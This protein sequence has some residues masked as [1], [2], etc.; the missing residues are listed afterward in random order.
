MVTVL[1]KTNSLVSQFLVELRDKNIQLDA[2][3]FRLNMHRLGN[4]FAY[5][6][7]K[8]L[9]FEEVQV[10]T[11]LGISTEYKIKDELCLAVLL[12][13]GLPLHHGL[14]DFFPNAANGFISANRHLHKHGALSIDLDY[15]T[16]PDIEN[17][18]LII[19]DAMIA[20]GS[21]MT[22][23]LEAIKEKG[24]PSRIHIVAAIASVDGVNYLK[25]LF[26]SAHIWIAAQDEE[27]TAKSYVVPGLGDA[28]DL[29]F[30]EK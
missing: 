4:I 14:L 2:A 28:G 7:S 24:K 9:K 19:C 11:P 21:S 17:K 22:K 15:I 23:C 8:T 29:S 3:R 16:V 12:R 30:G 27:L 20:T 5:E 10:E 18:V 26:P 13:A 25:R 1:N 6:I